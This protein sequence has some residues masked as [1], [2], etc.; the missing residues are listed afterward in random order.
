MYHLHGMYLNALFWH[1]FSLRHTM[2]P[3]GIPPCFI[4]PPVPHC[5]SVLQCILLRL[6]ALICNSFHLLCSNA[7]IRSTLTFSV[8]GAPTSARTESTRLCVSV[9]CVP[10]DFFVFY[11][12]FCHTTP[13]TSTLG[14]HESPFSLTRSLALT[15][16]PWLSG[17]P[18]LSLASPLALT[19]P[20]WLS[21][22]PSGSHESPLALTSP[23]LLSRASLAL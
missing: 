21:R 22:V 15:S 18:F 23:S 2:C 3:Q 13:L 7:T 4:A 8:V 14:S 9:H 17:V 6:D 1:S 20:L 16:P 19:N 11:D 5:T 12:V 10:M